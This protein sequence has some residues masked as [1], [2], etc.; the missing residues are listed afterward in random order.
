MMRPEEGTPWR[1]SVCCVCLCVSMCVSMCVCV[2][3]CVSVCVCVYVCLCVSMCMCV[4]VCLCVCVFP[5][6]VVIG[7]SLQR[8]PAS[9]PA[10]MASRRLSS[11]RRGAGEE[12]ACQ[13]LR[14]LV[15]VADGGRRR[16]S[17]SP[18]RAAGNKDGAAG[19]R[20][21]KSNKET[22]SGGR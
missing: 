16:L 20:S 9:S 13:R 17:T 4:C 6:P 1:C 21:L 15:I 12:R 5:K 18:R 8:V 10:A 19:G 14:P 2:C 3:L 11:G 7:E 22:F